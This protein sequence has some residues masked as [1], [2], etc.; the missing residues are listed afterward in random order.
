MT[1]KQERIASKVR[2]LLAISED[3][4]ASNAEIQNAMNHAQR[5]MDS[6]HLTEEDLAHEP[7]DDYRKVD[8]AEFDQAR[9]FVGGRA[10]Y[11]EKIL[12]TFVSHF[13]GVPVYYDSEKRPIRKRSGFTPNGKAKYGRS[14]VFY[15]V[16][17]DAAIAA[18]TYDELRTLIATMAIG[19]WSTVY[20]G[21]GAAYA[22]GFVSGLLSQL[23]EAKRIEQSS[24]GNALIL[25]VRRNDII[26]YKT[27][28]AKEWLESEKG[29]VVGA[30]RKGGGTKSGARLAFR[31]GQSDGASTD[32]STTRLKKLCP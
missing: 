24:G 27:D 14:F 2:K 28:K 6:H 11:W 3:D 12:A 29:V 21:D 32:V 31:E 30:S 26:K 20:K 4:A 18:E 13:V 23:Q 8:E 10:F 5:L 7:D 17:D 25:A 22:E 15:G 1:D 9:A 19:K 16:A